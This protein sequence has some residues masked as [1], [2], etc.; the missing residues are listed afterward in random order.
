MAG[1][2]MSYLSKVAAELLVLDICLVS[3]LCKG[4]ACFPNANA[5]FYLVECVGGLTWA[6]FTALCISVVIVWLDRDMV[7]NE[8][9]G[10]FF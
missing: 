7:V 8:R 4:L 1:K 3:F 9:R 6:G 10:G 2:F 5:S